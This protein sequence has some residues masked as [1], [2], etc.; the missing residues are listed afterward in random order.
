M[1]RVLEVN[2]LVQYFKLSM[3]LL[4]K[5]SF[6]DGK[7]QINE[8]KVHAVNDVSFHLDAG[9][10]YSLV[11][12]S[13]CGKSSTARTIVKLIEPKAGTVKFL[14]DD[15]T[16]LSPRKMLPYRKKMQMIF[17]DPYASLNPRQR[18]I[19][20]ITEPILFHKMESTQKAAVERAKSILERVGISADQADRYPHQF[21]GGQRQRIGIARAL[22]VDPQLIIADEP[23][24]ALDVSIQAQILNLL[25]DLKDEYGFSYL[26]IA[27][28]LS[29]VRH[30]SDR[31]G[32]MY[33][34]M[35]VEEGPKEKVF[36]SPAHPYT[37]LLF[38]AVPQIEKEGEFTPVVLDGEIPSPINLPP[39]CLFCS[40]C[41][42]MME[43]CKH[44]RPEVV[45]LSPGHRVRC[46]LYTKPEE[47]VVYE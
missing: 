32:I 44:V 21:S 15:I 26:F 2:H 35:I 47:G 20:I 33:L 45:E 14:G 29:V 42:K 36:S 18:V 16:N 28:D 37:Q 6:K 13:G 34:G 8:K 24:S 11:G 39:G 22:A 3:D 25:M 4:D 38:S 23:V 46:H 41:D 31:M 43:I 40:R 10:V 7:L 9:E 19:D 5:V 27:H 30:I 1:S 17:Q 12:E